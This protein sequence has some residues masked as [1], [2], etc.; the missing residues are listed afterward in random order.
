MSNARRQKRE[1]GQAL[2]EFALVLP[3]L[4]MLILGIVQFGIVF[5]DYVALTDAVRAGAR[6][7]SVT[8]DASAA[9]AA[10]VNS[11]SEL[12]PSDLAVD[13]DSSWDPGSD[14]TVTAT[15]PYDISLLGVVIKSGRLSAKTTDRVE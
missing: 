10:V 8:H 11:A 1:R 6:Q 13:V 2:V 5:H 7:G 12:N 4:A 14:V 3:I 15:Y 9:S